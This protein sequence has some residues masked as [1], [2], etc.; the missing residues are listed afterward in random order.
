MIT[1][2]ATREAAIA[3]VS[4]ANRGDVAEITA[5]LD[6]YDIAEFVPAMHAALALTR[7]LAV[8]LRTASGLMA[9]DVWLS[10]TA[11]EHPSRDTRLAAALILAHAM[12]RYP[13]TE[14]IATAET[15]GDMHN[16]GASTFN[17]ICC[18]ADERIV[19]VLVAVLVLW[20]HL[21]PELNI[22][23]G[24]C[25]IGNIAGELWGGR[26]AEQF[27]V[28]I[29]NTAPEPDRYEEARILRIG[30]RA[31][32][33]PDVERGDVR[34]TL[35]IPSGLEGGGPPPRAQLPAGTVLDPRG[36]AELRRLQR[37]AGE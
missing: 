30:K 19:E 5:T 6:A 33:A 34:G 22:A 31:E 32:N 35:V 24:A 25:L 10:E 23:S 18:E 27:G 4:A 7:S 1:A 29:E 11:R 16:I 8:Q 12:T 17:E 36:V 37:D 3:I 21:L 2:P 28:P 14:T 13:P 9:A 26:S 15:F 20:R